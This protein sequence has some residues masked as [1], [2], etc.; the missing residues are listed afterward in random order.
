[1]RAAQSKPWPRNVRLGLCLFACALLFACSGRKG[2]P[3]PVPECQEYEKLLSTCL[4]R[5]VA[6]ASQKNLLPATDADRA[7]VKATCADG[8]TRLKRACR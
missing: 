7:I 4:H 1:M 6:F 5:D 8:L 3:E 2:V